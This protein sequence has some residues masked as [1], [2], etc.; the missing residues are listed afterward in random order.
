MAISQAQRTEMHQVLREKLTMDAADTLMEYLPPN[1]W[2]E[3]ATKTDLLML[4]E[5]LNAR[6]D[7]ALAANNKWMT[8]ILASLVVAMIVALVR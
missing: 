6:I 5:R 2:D 1:G 4:E 7:R 8:G 3:V